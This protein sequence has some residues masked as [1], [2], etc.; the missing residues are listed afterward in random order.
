[1]E[2][3][4]LG[5][6]ISTKNE[7]VSVEDLYDQLEQNSG[8]ENLSLKLPR[9]IFFEKSKGDYYKGMILTIRDQ[10]K[11]CK[12]QDQGG[13]ISINVENL[14]GNEKLLEFN[15]FVINKNT[16]R[17]IYQEYHHSCSINTFFKYLKQEFNK[18]KTESIKDE[19]AN[20]QSPTDKDKSA[21][22]K[23]HK[24]PI[25][26]SMLCDKSDLFDAIAELTRV[27]SL[28]Y[29]LETVEPHQGFG[30]PLA[31]I[32]KRKREAII[33]EDVKPATIAD[34]LRYHMDSLGIKKG[35]ITGYESKDKKVSYPIN[36]RPEYYGVYD[37]DVIA[38]K[39]HNI[40]SDKFTECKILD[41]LIGTCKS[42]RYKFTFETYEK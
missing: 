24:K 15:F 9:R 6:S 36:Q 12:M 32:C 27:S 19:I 21:I 3:R 34:T 14:Q 28:E 37:F 40:K 16:G 8:K 22:R 33:F 20:L 4:Y 7:K 35:R 42:N 38:P 2:V 17:G 26:L 11:Y 13:N 23:K 39:V 31:D 41:D 10:T 29:T 25:D 18:V 1:M 5:F 30:K